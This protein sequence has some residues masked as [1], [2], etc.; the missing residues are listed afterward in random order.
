MRGDFFGLQ[1]PDRRI[2]DLAGCGEFS[3]ALPP[4]NGEGARQAGDFAKRLDV[5]IDRIEKI[6]IARI[7][8]AGAVAIAREQGVQR[9]DPDRGVAG[10]AGRFRQF[11]ERGEVADPLIAFAAQAVNLGGDAGRAGVERRRPGAG[12]RRDDQSA[13]LVVEK[14][15]CIAR[16]AA[17]AGP[18]NGQ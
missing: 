1:R 3:R 15:A 5:E 6:A 18:R 12:G 9:I 8:G 11:R 17:A 13:G 2:I 16:P 10:A 7:I 4:L 14:S